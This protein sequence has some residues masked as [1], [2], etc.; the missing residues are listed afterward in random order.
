MNLMEHIGQHDSHFFAE[1]FDLAKKSAPC[2][3]HNP[4]CP[5]PSGLSGPLATTTGFSCKFLSRSYNGEAGASPE[6]ERWIARARQRLYWEY[7]PGDDAV[8]ER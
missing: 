8:L 6:E 3:T 5:M 4:E 1:L 7:F 2:H